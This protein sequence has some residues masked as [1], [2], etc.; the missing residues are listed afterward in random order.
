MLLATEQIILISHFKFRLASKPGT[1]TAEDIRTQTVDV[2][3]QPGETGP[4]RVVFDIV[5]DPLVEAQE[6]FYV[7]FASSTSPA[8]T[9]G[10]QAVVNIRDND[11]K[12]LAVMFAIQTHIRPPNWY[13]GKYMQCP[14]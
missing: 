1:A 10:E 7:S 12:S 3:F 2:T 4:K 8:V 5:D 6:N 13:L 11:G 14:L 9:F